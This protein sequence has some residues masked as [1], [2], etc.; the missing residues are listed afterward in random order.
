MKLLTVPLSDLIK[1]YEIE[2]VERYLSTFFCKKNKDV[3]NFLKIRAIEYEKLNN[4]RTF[5]IVDQEN[6]NLVGYFTL[7]LSSIDLVDTKL[8]GRKKHRLRYGNSNKNLI[9]GFLIGQL[10][11]N[12]SVSKDSFEGSKIL[13]YALYYL[14]KSHDI[15]GGKFVLIDCCTKLVDFYTKNGF[16]EIG[17]EKGLKKCLKLL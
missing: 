6:L 7:A 13:E 15:I 5:L 16:V 12:D 8:S 11:R 3:E 1:E 9:P 17:S 4:S 2:K 10:A 14:N